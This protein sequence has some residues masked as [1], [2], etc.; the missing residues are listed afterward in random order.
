MVNDCLCPPPQ[1]PCFFYECVILFVHFWLDWVFVALRAFSSCRSWAL[2]SIV[3]PRL[4]IAVASVVE[5]PGSRADGLGSF[6][7]SALEHTDLGAGRPVRSSQV[8]D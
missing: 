2:L 3:V 8:R 7:S 6:S 1:C 5:T 4:L